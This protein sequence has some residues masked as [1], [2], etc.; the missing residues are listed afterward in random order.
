MN[1]TVPEAPVP[2]RAAVNV[3]GVAVSV[4]ALDVD[5]VSGGAGRNFATIA[6]TPVALVD[7]NAPAVT[8]KLL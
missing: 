6:E 2:A 8:G 5:N 7:W 3:I 4:I 1:V